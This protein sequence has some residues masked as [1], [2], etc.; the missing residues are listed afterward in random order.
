MRPDV[1]TS[2]VSALAARPTV[3][4]SSSFDASVVTGAGVVVEPGAGPDG[5]QA[6]SARR[7]S[8]SVVARAPRVR[9]RVVDIEVS[10]PFVTV[11]VSL[12]RVVGGVRGFRAGR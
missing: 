4:W 9:R 10:S 2:R 7:P 3:S 6:A 12:L 11:R 1:E 5:A 8:A